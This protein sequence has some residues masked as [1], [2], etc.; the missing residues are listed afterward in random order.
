MRISESWLREWVDPELKTQG[1]ADCLTMAGLEVDGIEPVS[2]DLVN[3]VVGQIVKA[4]PHPEADRLQ[5]CQ[6]LV[7]N[8][9]QLQIVCG[10][11]NAREGLKAPVALVGAVLPGGM[12]IKTATLRGVDSFGMLC[13]A[14]ELGLSEQ[15]D[16]LMELHGDMKPGQSL[17][18]AL[19]LDDKA[20]EIDLTPNRGDCLSVAGIARELSALTAT[21]LT[22]VKITPVK[23]AS[24]TR[25]N[26]SLEAGSDCPHYV[27]R[28]IEDI[29]P[30]AVTPMWMQERLRRSG[31]RSLGPCIDVTNYILLELG[32]PMHAFDLGRLNGNIHVKHCQ[33]KT[34]LELLD[35]STRDI[36]TGSLL[37]ADDKGPV[38]LAGI[39]GGAQSAV[40]DDTTNIFL[41]SAYFAPSAIAGRARSLGLQTDSS[42]RFERGVDP[43]LQKDALERATALLVDIVGGKPGPVIEKKLAKH[44]PRAMAIVVRHKRVE[45]VLGIKLASGRIQSYLKRLGMTVKAINGGWKVT[46]PSYRFDIAREE[47]LIEEV[48]RLYGYH[49]IPETMP[50][51][52]L[53]MAPVPETQV[54]THDVARLLTSRDYQEVVTYSFVDPEMQQRLNP[55]VQAIPLANP[56][57]SDLAVMR[58]NLWP[59]LLKVVEHNLNRQQYRIRI[60]ETGHR[61]LKKGKGS[62]EEQMLAMALTGPASTPSWAEKPR[63][64]DFFDLKGDLEAVLGLSG[65]NGEDFEFQATSHPALHPGQCAQISRNGKNIGWIG[66]LHPEISA[67]S[68]F[69]QAVYLAEVAISAIQGDK[70]AKFREISRFPAIDRDLAVVLPVE[71]PASEVLKLVRAAAGNWLTDLQL[72]DDYRG[73]GIDSGRKSLGLGLTLQD[74]SRTLKEV[75]IEGVIEN[76]LGVLRRELGAELR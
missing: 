33:K 48:A 19:A 5:V 59:G 16:G 56:I 52:I 50:Q 45:S 31:L 66:A 27:G 54:S 67:K 22:P 8:K 63:Q 62:L 55:E 26:I 60:F 20:I 28:V 43:Q 4:G 46:A 39:M 6:V 42:H 68:D 38:A 44:L 13:S 30:A 36:E 76:I 69:D 74:S 64:M 73:E 7:G 70:I 72:F 57:A 15:S 21:R 17:F 2:P 40:S 18:K 37:I 53:D 47:D 10:A 32:Q 24:K 25:I 35:G 12:E 61:F 9:K 34:R 58:T 75:E 49:N 65:L 11:A 1:I 51:G 41:E 14:K 29:D 71:T 3:I 23:A